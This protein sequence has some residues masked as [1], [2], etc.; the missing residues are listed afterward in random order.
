MWYDKPSSINYL[1][2]WRCPIFVKLVKIDKLDVKSKK[3][4]FIGHLKEY[5]RYYFYF[6]PNQRVSISRIAYFLEKKFLQ[7]GEVRRRIKFKENF[8][9]PQIE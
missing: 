4:R 5:L 6:L 1:K 9:E 7:K 8:K 2:I 3:G